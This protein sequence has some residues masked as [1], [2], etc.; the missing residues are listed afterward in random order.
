M[1]EDEKKFLNEQLAWVKYR[2]Q[3]L[4][5]I[6]AKLQEMKVLA[7]YAKNHQEDSEELNDIQLKVNKLQREIELLEREQLNILH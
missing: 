7:E 1:N 3:L 4:T 2:I 5:K 6:E